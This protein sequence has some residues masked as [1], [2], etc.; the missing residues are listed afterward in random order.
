M[1]AWINDSDLKMFAA[2]AKG[3]L[4]SHIQNYA[5]YIKEEAERIAVARFG[6]SDAKVTK[7]I[8]DGVIKLQGHYVGRPSSWFYAYLLPRLEASVGGVLCNALF[9]KEQNVW[10]GILIGTCLLLLGVGVFLS[11]RREKR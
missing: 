9:A 8:I 11:S 6:S 5:E 2:A 7:E 1:K 4:A 10:T 3:A